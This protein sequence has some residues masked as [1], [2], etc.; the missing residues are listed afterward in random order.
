MTYDRTEVSCLVSRSV[1]KDSQIDYDLLIE[2]ASA[3]EK[4]L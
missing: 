3:E 1:I 4:G 2:Q